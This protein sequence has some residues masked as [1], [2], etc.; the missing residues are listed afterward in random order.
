MLKILKWDQKVT[1]ENIF[2]NVFNVSY[3]RAELI[4]QR[5]LEDFLKN[6]GRFSEDFWK[7]F[8]RFC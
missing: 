3:R 1:L 7:I 4:K 2:G 5:F 8:G 6:F